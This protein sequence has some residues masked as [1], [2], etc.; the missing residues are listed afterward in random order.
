MGTQDSALA[1][2]ASLH[3]HGFETTQDQKGVVVLPLR[4][5][6]EAEGVVRKP[7]VILDII[8]TRHVGSEVV[9]GAFPTTE[10]LGFRVVWGE[11]S[12]GL[13]GERNFLVLE[14]LVTLLDI[15]VDR[16][17]NFDHVLSPFSRKKA[18]W[19]RDVNVRSLVADQVL[20]QTSRVRLN[21]WGQSGRMWAP[22]HN[23]NLLPGE[24]PDA[25]WGYFVGGDC[26]TRTIRGR[27][28]GP[29]VKGDIP[30]SFGKLSDPGGGTAKG[31]FLILLGGKR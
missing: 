31:T 14:H 23:G 12:Q 15:N 25:V 28:K 6:E 11:S 16:N 17:D 10:R 20:L 3:A 9:T 19:F 4:V 24:I 26:R 21:A 1:L 30:S 29:R 18:F 7:I 27:N 5:E 13:Q 8:L 2:G 22:I